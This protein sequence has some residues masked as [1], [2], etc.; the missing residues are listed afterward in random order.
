M[1]IGCIGIIFSYSLLKPITFWKLL[2]EARLCSTG[3]TAA[4]RCR[5]QQLQGAPPK[6]L[7]GFG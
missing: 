4:R 1:R 3:K 2:G 7:A 5:L 6:V